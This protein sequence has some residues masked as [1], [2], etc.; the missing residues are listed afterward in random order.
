[1]SD[2]L[3]VP[4]LKHLFRKFDP[5]TDKN[6]ASI[7]AHFHIRQMDSADYRSA[8]HQ[9]CD[10]FYGWNVTDTTDYSLGSSAPEHFK[11]KRVPREINMN[12]PGEQLECERIMKTFE[13]LFM[14]SRRVL[15]KYYLD[16]EEMV[17]RI[18]QG[19]ATI[20]SSKNKQ[21]D[22]GEDV[23]KEDIWK[24][25]GGSS[26]A[27]DEDDEIDDYLGDEDELIHRKMSR[28]AD[29]LVV[30]RKAAGAKTPDLDRMDESAGAQNEL[31]GEDGEKLDGENEETSREG[32]QT[33]PDGEKKEG[34]A[35]MSPS[36]S[37]SSTAGSDNE[38]KQAVG[39]NVSP[40][41]NNKSQSPDKDGVPSR[42]QSAISPGP[43]T[44][45][46]N[47]PQAGFQFMSA[48]RPH[49][50][51]RQGP[52]ETELRRSHQKDVNHIYAEIDKCFDYT[53]I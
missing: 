26:M 14:I 46:S 12:E 9:L 29:G 24:Q 2:R 48:P 5:S 28:T 37:R 31:F 33:G 19:L 36:S 34:N 51:F 1:M 13:T 11:M 3:N 18:G 47:L 23:D 49:G 53:L 35:P 44:A 6:L 52:D 50:F 40:N 45:P 39:G 41:N 30:K 20:S 8:Y 25:K 10:W 17:P 15:K 42:R 4:L 21:E 16:I 22:E 32:A 27:N 7:I 38:E 43:I